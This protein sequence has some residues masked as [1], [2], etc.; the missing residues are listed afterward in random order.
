[1]AQ[2]TS[3]GGGG[4]PSAAELVGSSTPNVLNIDLSLADTEVLLPIPA[5]C[6]KFTLRARVTGS[7]KLA[8]TMGQSGIAYFTVPSGCSYSEDFITTS[9]I[10]YIQSPIE[11]Q[12]VEL[13]TWT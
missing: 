3:S 4:V 2:F 7:L 6:K 12:V 1:M 11:S 8:Y 10:I 9:N 5:D 13:I